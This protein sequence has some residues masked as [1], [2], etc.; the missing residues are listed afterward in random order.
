[1]GSIRGT[2]QAAFGWSPSG[3][4]DATAALRTKIAEGNGP[5]PASSSQATEAQKQI[6]D[7]QRD[8]D[9]AFKQLPVRN[10]DFCKNTAQRIK[11]ELSDYSQHGI[12]GD[13]NAQRNRISS[14]TLNRLAKVNNS[15]GLAAELKRISN[16]VDGL[17]DGSK[18]KKNAV[19]PTILSK[20]CLRLQV[21]IMEAA[22][23]EQPTSGNEELR[24]VTDMYGQINRLNSVA[25]R[26]Y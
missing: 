16:E 2:S 17:I 19:I 11:D 25:R 23:R 13:I 22:I 18:K 20:E 4:S 14:E 21:G 7:F 8:F 24:L 5:P 3:A 10:N 15:A 1:M 6:S 12:L 26:P 9:N